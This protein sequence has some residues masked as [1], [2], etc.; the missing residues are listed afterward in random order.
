VSSLPTAHAEDVT[1]WLTV[2]DI[3]AELQMSK[4]A[5]QNFT[6]ARAGKD[7]LLAARF[8]RAIRVRRAVFEQWVRARE[9]AS[10]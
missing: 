9:R 7:R 10:A 5:I 2:A 6:S 4:R 3:A 8:G 1:S